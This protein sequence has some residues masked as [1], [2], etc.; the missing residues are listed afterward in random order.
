MGMSEWTEKA[1]PRT[2]L[3][4]QTNETLLRASQEILEGFGHRVL[5]AADLDAAQALAAGHDGA[6]DLAVVEAFPRRGSGLEL[7]RLLRRERPDLRALLLT[8]YGEDAAL[9]QAV[10]AHEVV[11]LPLPFSTVAL[12]RAVATAL[13]TPVPSAAAAPAEPPAGGRRRSVPA[14]A[15]AAAAGLAAAVLLVPLTQRGGP[16]PL[17]ER[18]AGDVTRTLTILPVAPRGEIETAPEALSWEA[19]A[20]A[21]SYRVEIHAVDGTLLWE[22]RSDAPRIPLDDAAV[23]FAPAVRYSWRVEA[24]DE[25]GGTLASSPSVWMLVRP[26]RP[27]PQ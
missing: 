12:R 3:L 11:S 21:V 2:V 16:P 1:Q 9:R 18:G 24:L 7:V 14:W 15:W 8:A 10:E 25:A 6:I 26:A 22:G 17:A 13:G 19:V 23:A 4:V 27:S 20:D 5:A